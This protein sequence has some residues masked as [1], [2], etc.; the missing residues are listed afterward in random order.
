MSGAIGR[1]VHDPFD[2]YAAQQTGSLRRARPCP[3]GP[4]TA[5]GTEP[6]TEGD[7]PG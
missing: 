2:L 4:R 5:N 3:E 7:R 6:G 1:V